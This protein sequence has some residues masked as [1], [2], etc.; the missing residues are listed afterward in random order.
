MSK[1]Y[2][3]RIYIRKDIILKLVQY[4]SLNQTMLLSLCGLNLQKHKEILSDLES[5]GLIQKSEESWGSKKITM[6]S[7]TQKG[8]EFCEKILEPYEA[9]FPRKKG[10]VEEAK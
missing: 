8:R 7:P 1:E 9:M 2:R 4:R 6:Y 5:K 10:R 3:D